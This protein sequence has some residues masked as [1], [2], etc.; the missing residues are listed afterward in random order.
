ME[1]HIGINSFYFGAFSYTFAS[2]VVGEG[3]WRTG[4]D[5]TIGAIISPCL[6]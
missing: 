2:G 1:Q 6:D 4:S 3:F 5:T